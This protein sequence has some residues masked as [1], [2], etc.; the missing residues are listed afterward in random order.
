VSVVLEPVVSQA[1]VAVR[2]TPILGL[3]HFIRNELGA[4]R[5]AAVLRELPEPYGSRFAAA[6]FLASD[7]VPLSVVNQATKLAARAKGEPVESFAERAGHFGASE[8]IRTVFKPLFLILSVA[9]ALAVAPMMWTRIYDTGKM[10]V[11]STKNH[12]VIHVR[13]FPGD[14][15][16]CSRITGW[17][18]YIGKLS[19]ARNL[20][21]RH[22]A[23]TAKGGAE[24]RWE[25]DW[26]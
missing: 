26:E 23:C 4:E 7:R 25:F 10:Q 14:E 3:C 8:G 11:E 1:T 21:S 12:A 16:G 9:N 5:A 15:A 20:K 6:S 2:G 18:R 19:G 22:D 17:F 24:C 13:E